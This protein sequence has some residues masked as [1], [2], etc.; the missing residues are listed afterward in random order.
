MRR[1]HTTP[2][3]E[4]LEDRCVPTHA[5][6]SGGILTVT[7]TAGNNTVVIQDN[8]NGD[9]T[10]SGD[11]MS[12][13]NCSNV[14]RINIDMK[15]GKDSVT[16][17]QN[18]NRTR[19]MDLNVQLG[20]GNDTFLAYVNGNVN[21]GRT[22][23]VN[24]DGGWGKDWIKVDADQDVD[25]GASANLLLYLHGGGGAYADELF[26]WYKG[27]NDGHISARMFGGPGIVMDTLHLHLDRDAGSGGTYYPEVDS[28]PGF[29]DVL[30]DV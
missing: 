10:V 22:L 4:A 7:G 11:G 17:K 2:R 25:L 30:I 16:Y 20:T 14:Y 12:A 28:G 3:V 1:T 18:G 5:S 6:L 23:D 21:A 15:G 19:S 26:V 24:V 27:E 8:G 9:L 13:S 29:D